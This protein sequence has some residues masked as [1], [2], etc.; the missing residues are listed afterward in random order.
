MHGPDGSHI[1]PTAS[2][3]PNL[4]TTTH[5]DMT[6]TGSDGKPVEGAVVRSVITEKASP[7]VPVHQTVSEF[8]AESKGYSF[9][10][11]YSAAGEYV[12][13]QDVVL[14]DGKQVPVSF[15]IHVEP[16]ATSGEEE[17][18]HGP[19]IP[20]IFGGIAAAILALAIAYRLGKKAGGPPTPLA[21]V[22]GLMLLF[23]GLAP[24][25][26]ANGDEDG[27]A[28]GPNGEHL[29][30]S[31]SEGKAAPQFRAFANEDD[32]TTA[33]QTV[34][35]Y[36]FVLSLEN[37]AVEPDRSEV[38]VSEADADIIGLKTAKAVASTTA[39]GLQATG[40]VSANPNGLV[41]VDARAS[42]RI[43]RLGAL[44]GTE[45]TRGQVLAVIE[46]TDLAD[47][48]AAHRTAVADVAQSQAGVKVAESSLVAVRSELEIAT[49]NLA[50]QR[51]L[52][53]AGAFASPALDAARKDV[54]AAKSATESA[55]VEVSRLTSLVSRLRDGFASGV[56]SRR[57]V[58]QADAD[59][60]AAKS[61][62]ADRQNQL[63]IADTVLERE[64]AIA[65]RGLRNAKE[66]D[67]AQA[68]LDLA[69]SGVQSASSRVAQAK[70][71]LNRAQTSVRL[72]ADQIRLL[73]GSTRGSSQVL[74][75]APISGEVEERMVSVGQ[76]VAQGEALYELLNA[77]VVWVLADI[78]EKDIPKVRL[79]Q[80]IEVVPD[81]YP[82]R[83]YVGEVAFIHKD[84]DPETRTTAVRIV[85]DNPGEML[86][87]DMFVKVILQ[88][89]PESLVTI[90]TAAVQSDKGLD[91]VFVQIEPGR[92]RRQLV[93]V[94]S[95]IGDRTVVRGI[96]VGQTVATSGSYQLLSMAGGR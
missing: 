48:I 39:G 11:T 36:T 43:V 31:A 69:R 70:A 73:G 27:H 86:K 50:R 46:S 94:V 77:E 76:T 24:L 93:Q 63:R 6:I 47:A 10:F 83:V 59:L 67:E 88:T 72:A 15:D 32:A 37:E 54:S 64:E 41:K 38:T 17:H 57:D 84:V 75:T 29:P 40:K 42:G 81:A 3:E 12:L 87:Q 45:V 79:G 91:V 4:V 49:R 95:K 58:E 23:G 52:V 28:H 61:G 2:A 16:V 62:L 82:E 35:G 60:A 66:V 53:A 44:P 85:I 22:L 26:Y 30:P 90:P 25:A 71:D 7:A 9:H 78:Y 65:A 33:T 14:P 96:D 1:V 19:N 21:G 80:R 13:N 92:F 5:H 68:R 34:D 74:I 55:E 18:A 51:Q 56:V 20:L 89:D 8:E